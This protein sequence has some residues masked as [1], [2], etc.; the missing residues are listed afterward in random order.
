MEKKLEKET[1]PSSGAKL[2]KVLH[3][4]NFK[5]KRR[6]GQNF[7]SDRNLLDKIADAA[8]IGPEDIV[9][10]IGPGAATLTRVLAERAKAVVA[11]EIDG[12][13]LPI[14]EDVMS[15][16]DNFHLV[17][18][19]ALKLNLDKTVR[20]AAGV[21]Q[22]YKMVSN[23]P[24]Y[25]TTP[26]VMRFLEEGCSVDKMVVMVQK[27]VA[28]RF[29][30]SPGGKEY[31]AVTVALQYYA[32]VRTAFHVPRQMF[33]PRP[34]VDSAV[35]EITPWTEKPF[36]AKDEVLFRQL[37]KAAFGQR[38]KMLSNALKNL[39][40]DDRIVEHALADCGIDG[41][42]RG[43]ALSVGQFAALSNALSDRIAEA[44]NAA[45]SIG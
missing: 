38:R 12:E 21:S 6:Y 1:Q 45:G 42:L 19:D 10:E 3:D 33:I 32:Q 39:K 37:V 31:G 35:I 40:I 23:L 44:K 26:I 2:G 36:A 16:Y 8:Q 20:T 28:E 7:I 25:I 18:G 41:G 13:L 43:E 24:Y 11:I 29:S 30:A 5:F 27:E 9:L 14:I 15:G 17:K 22:R 34:D 4:Y